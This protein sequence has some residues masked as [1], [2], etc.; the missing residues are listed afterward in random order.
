MKTLNPA[1]AFPHVRSA[2]YSQPW[3]ITKEWLETICEVTEAHISGRGPDGMFQPRRKRHCPNCTAGWMRITVPKRDEHSA[4]VAQCDCPNCGC[5]CT[6][7][8]LAP[9]DIVNGVAILQLN[10]PL[11]PKAN[12]FTMFS[13]ATSYDQ[14]GSDFSQ[15][16]DDGD[17]N[18]I[19]IQSDSPGGSCLGMSELCSRLFTAREEGSKLMIG[20][21]DPMACSAAYAVI[22]QCDRVLISESGMAGSIGTVLK[23]SNWDRAERNEGNDA[24]MLASSDVKAFGTPQSLAQYQS[25][26]DNLLAYFNQFKEIVLRGRQGI[27]IE[28]VSGAKTWIGKEAVSMGLVDGVSTMEKI[29]ADLTEK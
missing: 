2:I 24:V 25:L 28:K 14:F 11:F 5:Q 9:Y 29:I 6:E 12:F 21:I 13:G 1:S 19:L 15:A 22:S 18:A 17:V 10:G 7:E 16:M 26:I 27:D 8:D 3:A 4:P 20:F 23:Y